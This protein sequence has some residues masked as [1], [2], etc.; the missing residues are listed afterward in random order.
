M[1]VKHGIDEHLLPTTYGHERARSIW[2]SMYGVGVLPDVVTCERV[3]ALDVLD[4]LAP[5]WRTNV[6]VATSEVVLAMHEP[7]DPLKS[8]SKDYWHGIYVALP[9][10]KAIVCSKYGTGTV[11]LIHPKGSGALE[12][13]TAACL[14]CPKV[15]LPEVFNVHVPV[16]NSSGGLALQQF[17]LPP[18]PAGDPLDCYNED[19]APVHSRILR[20]LGDV[21]GRG[22][23]V[24]H[25][26][27]GT[28]KTSYI[29]TLARLLPNKKVVFVPQDM[30][31][32]LSTPSAM[33]FLANHPQ[34]VLVIE[35]AEQVL[36]SRSAGG[37]R[38]AV[39]TLLNLTDGLL[40]DCLRVQVI[41]TFNDQLSSVDPAL[42]RAGR[43][44]AK[45]EFGPLTADRAARLAGLR[46]LP[47]PGK[48]LTLAELFAAEPLSVAA[49]KRGMGFVKT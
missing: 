12:V 29:R 2:Y 14:A 8:P 19:F 45:Y 24:L 31:E 18:P 25:G 40:A 26:A 34:S 22:M 35:D 6:K 37:P 5:D 17:E 47:D 23:V 39:S 43:L 27:A 48:P 9:E 41:C 21:A 10:H 1:R 16:P 49:E 33:P 46:G 36:R 32:W 7:P 13:F 11:A 20:G 42:L 38:G 3:V 44:L 30:A 28:G 4:K 15:P